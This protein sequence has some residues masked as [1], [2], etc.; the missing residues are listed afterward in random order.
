[1]L[2]RRFYLRR[3]VLR[4]V[5]F[6]IL[7][8]VNPDGVDIVLN[9]RLQWVGNGR[10]LPGEEQPGP[11]FYYADANGDG[12]ITQM[13]VLDPHGEW[14][15]SKLDS[16][17]LTLR[18]PDEEDDG[19]YYRL[20]PEGFFHAW[21]GVN[22]LFEQKPLDGNLNR[23]YPAH[24]QPERQPPGWPRSWANLLARPWAIRFASTGASVRQP[25]SRCSPK[26][27]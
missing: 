11:G 3:Q 24:W 7:P 19:P 8:I 27:F 22:M 6:Y 15:V 2:Y 1:M 21:D 10:Y 20:L 25:E 16:R 23:N 5:V 9:R 17:L 26:A 4:R 13:R 12:L 18:A 14:K